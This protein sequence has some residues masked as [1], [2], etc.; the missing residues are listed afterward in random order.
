MT[1]DHSINNIF[2]NTCFCVNF[3][4]LSL[5]KIKFMLRLRDILILFLK[6]DTVEKCI[7]KDLSCSIP[8]LTLVVCHKNQKKKAALSTV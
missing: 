6:Y 7:L 1:S 4:T 8:G 5:T 3:V 2:L